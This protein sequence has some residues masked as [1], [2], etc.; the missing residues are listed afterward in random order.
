MSSNYCPNCG[1]SLTQQT[2]FCPNCGTKL[3]I[4]QS[5]QSAPEYR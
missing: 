2:S 4:Q 5:Y 1:T 3:D